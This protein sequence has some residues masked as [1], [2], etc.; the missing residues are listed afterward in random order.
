MSAA[1]LAVA[2]VLATSQSAMAEMS[3]PVISA[4]RGQLVVSQDELPEGKN[5]KDTIAKIKKAQVKELTGTASDDVTSWTFHYAAFLTKTGSKELK[6]R[7]M[8]G[9]QLSA[10]K[11][12]DGIDPKTPVLIGDININ[13]DEGLAKGNTYTIELV[14]GSDAVVAKTTLVMK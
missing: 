13:E 3:R 10:D 2:A 12:L 5:D 8:K 7:F 14:N 11:R 9:K 6:M 1:A 4:F